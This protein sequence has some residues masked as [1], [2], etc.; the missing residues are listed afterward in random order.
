MSETSDSEEVEPKLKYLRLSNDLKRILGQDAISTVKVHSRV[1][2]R[3]FENGL[4]FCIL[5]DISSTCALER[6]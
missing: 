5:S 4:G 6:T 2:Q 1:S 3:D